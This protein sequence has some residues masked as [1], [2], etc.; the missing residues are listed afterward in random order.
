M[1]FKKLASLVDASIILDVNHA[2][3]KE[4]KVYYDP[5]DEK[6]FFVIAPEKFKVM[7]D[8]AAIINAKSQIKLQSKKT[9]PRGSSSS[10]SS[11]S[12]E[13]TK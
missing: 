5:S 6:E 2:T 7:T 4:L 8:L 12:Q 3:M 9:P 13:P 1:N 10:S 11:S